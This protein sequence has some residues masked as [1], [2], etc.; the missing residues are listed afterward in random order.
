MLNEIIYIFIFIAIAIGT[1]L[2]NYYNRE[3]I[4]KFLNE[5]KEEKKKKNNK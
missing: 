5:I 1:Y 3:E 2:Y 4:E